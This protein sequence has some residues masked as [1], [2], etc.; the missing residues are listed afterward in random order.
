MNKWLDKFQNWKSERH[1]QIKKIIGRQEDECGHHR[2][3]NDGITHDPEG[4]NYH[5]QGHVKRFVHIHRLVKV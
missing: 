5:N 3:E 2:E 1:V 4:I